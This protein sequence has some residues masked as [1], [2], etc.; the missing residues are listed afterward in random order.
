MANGSN[1][2]LVDKYLSLPKSKRELVWIGLIDLIV[3]IILVPFFTIGLLKL[4]LGWLIGSIVAIVSHLMMNYSAKTI[5]SDVNQSKKS[6][7]LLAMVFFFARILLWAIVLVI[8][9]ICTFKSEWFNGF[10][11]FYFWT[12]FGAYFPA[13]IV[14][15]VSNM[16]RR[17][18]NSEGENK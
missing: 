16:R 14:L 17:V 13:T 9:G 12:T 5:L 15:L 6:G 8:S 10:D 7:T 1:S 11:L 4:S 18:S 3:F 2:K